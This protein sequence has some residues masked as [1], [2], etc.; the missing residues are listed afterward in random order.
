MLKFLLNRLCLLCR[1]SGFALCFVASV[2]PIEVTFTE[3]FVV[4]RTHVAY[5][6]GEEWISI[7]MMSSPPEASEEEE[8]ECK[9]DEDEKEKPRK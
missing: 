4:L 1:F 7:V 2:A 6:V 3:F 9:G 8:P 5:A